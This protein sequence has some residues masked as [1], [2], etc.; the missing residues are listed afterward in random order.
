MVTFI[1]RDD[2]LDKTLSESEKM[3]LV[4]SDRA[5]AS[6]VKTEADEE[7]VCWILMLK[8]GQIHAHPTGLSEFLLSS[9]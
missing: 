1:L 3:M 2:R 7:T 6:A 8:T 9:V 4:A 5:M